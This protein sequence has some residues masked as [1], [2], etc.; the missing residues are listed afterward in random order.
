VINVASTTVN[1]V[2]IT[3][4]GY[5]GFKIKYDNLVIFIDPSILPES[6]TDGDMADIILITHEHPAHCNP[7]SIRKVRGSN[8]TTL[9]PECMNLQF[10]GD[11]RRIIAG[12]LLLDELSIKG[13]NIRV[14]PAHNIK[15]S[16]HAEGQGVGYIIEVNGLLIYH[17]GDTDFIPDLG[18]DGRSVDVV[19][20]PIGGISVMGIS[21]AAQ[22]VSSLLPAMVIP[23]HYNLK[24]TDPEEFRAIV[25]GT[26]SSINVVI[27]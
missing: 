21:T 8:S 1:N 19:L 16:Y 27:L 6:I 18:L 17:T 9:I 26:D 7:D 23:M 12:D 10:R 24:T 3:W 22:A 11:T 5:A 25:G 4:L 13:I 2:S 14:V 20:L 15:S